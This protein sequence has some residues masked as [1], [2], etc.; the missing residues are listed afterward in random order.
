MSFN[1]QTLRS[2]NKVSMEVKYLISGKDD[3]I[4]KNPKSTEQET[5]LYI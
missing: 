1:Y 5:V 3:E 4:I 2:G